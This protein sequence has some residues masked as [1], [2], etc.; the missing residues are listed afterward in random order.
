MKKL[1]ALSMVCGMILLAGPAEAV[2][3]CTLD[4]K[5]SM[6]ANGRYAIL[7]HTVVTPKT[8]P[9][10]APFKFNMPFAPNQTITLREDRATLKGLMLPEA[11]S[12]PWR[13][14]FGDGHSALGTTVA[15]HY[16]RPGLYRIIV[17]AYFPSYKQWLNF[18]TVSLTVGS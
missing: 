17:Y 2:R 1:I 9:S 7:N 18:D 12:R 13:W 3:A 8:Y 16:T 14:T 15:H 6:A 10:W 4:G 11:F 5:P